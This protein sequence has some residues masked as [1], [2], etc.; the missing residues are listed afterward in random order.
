MKPSLMMGVATATGQ[1]VIVA[2]GSILTGL[3]TRLTGI[4][5]IPNVGAL[6]GFFFV[7]VLSPIAATEPRA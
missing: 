1:E 7:T 4:A 3:V 5:P 6:E 2:T